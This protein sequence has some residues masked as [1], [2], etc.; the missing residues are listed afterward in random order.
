VGDVQ[1]SHGVDLEVGSDAADAARDTSDRV[2]R[3]TL[4]CSAMFC[5]RLAS[6]RRITGGAWLTLPVVTLVAACTSTGPIASP[7]SPVP[8]TAEPPTAATANATTEA[9]T[10]TETPTTTAT[11]IETTTTIPL[12]E[13]LYPQVADG[14]LRIQATTCD[15][16]GI[17]TGFLV[18]PDLLVT[19]AHVVAGSVSLAVDDVAGAISGRVLG[20][21]SELDIALIN[22]AQPSTGH[23]F[24][25]ATDIPSPGAT[26]AAIGFPFNEPRTLTVGAISGVDRA[27]TVEGGQQ[28]DHLIQTDVAL[29]PGNSGGPLIDRRGDVVGVVSAGRFDAQ[30]T[31]YAAAAGLAR[32]LVEGWES[33][34]QEIDVPKCQALGPDLEVTVVPPSTQDALS[35]LAVTTFEAYF[36][37]INEGDYESSRLRLA[38]PRRPSAAKWADALATSYDF[39]IVVNQV[40][41]SGSGAIVWVTFTSLQAADKGPRAGETCTLWSID[42]SLIPADDG[43]LWL[44]HSAAHPGGSISQ[45][46]G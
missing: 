2:T 36:T 16:S 6:L 43:L 8:A 14:V 30:G 37:G 17:G 13:E 35:D 31:N 26:V 41:A 34:P 22:L 7:T 39:D 45:P 27:I 18:A 24:T 42:Y 20:L 12:L 28:I 10:T 29:N 25:L 11:T 5:T 4:Y 40:T 1:R 46:C 32:P 44:D 21:D 19:A 33:T 38:P 15:G 3:V 23:L 9:P